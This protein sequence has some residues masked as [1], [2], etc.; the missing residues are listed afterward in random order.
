MQES[1]S[2]QRHALGRTMGEKF[3]NKSSPYREWIVE[4]DSLSLA[5]KV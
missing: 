1:L 5:E 2:A 4:R 3:R